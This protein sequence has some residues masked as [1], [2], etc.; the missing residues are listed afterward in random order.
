MLYSKSFMF[1]Y[2][3]HSVYLSIP[4]AQMCVLRC[5]VMSNSL[6]LHGAH[7]AP[8]S[9]EFSRQEYWSGL[10]FPPPGDLPDPG[11]EPMS[12]ALAARFFTTMP[13]G[14]PIHSA[15]CILLAAVVSWYFPLVFSATAH[16]TPSPFYHVSG[17]SI[18]KP[19]SYYHEANLEEMTGRVQFYLTQ[20]F[21]CPQYL[22]VLFP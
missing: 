13:P 4:C 16:S 9:M 2:F 19:P 18:L 8:L 1:L 14:K 10:P 12:P 21:I 20:V 6:W 11:T 17:T 7:Q 5:L 3:I 15:G 22:A